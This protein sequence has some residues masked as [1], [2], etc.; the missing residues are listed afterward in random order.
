MAF[1]LIRSKG[2]VTGDGA[3]ITT[4]ALR[5]GIPAG[6]IMSMQIEAAVTGVLRKIDLATGEEVGTAEPVPQAERLKLLENLVKKR[7]PDAKVADV[8][9]DRAAN[10]DDLPVDP[11]D[12]KR[13][14]LSQLTRVIEAQ[15]EKVPEPLDNAPDRD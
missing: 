5:Q 3:L 14:P 13:M 6:L 2:P 10:L 9:E 7:L 8:E 11:E 12:V 1:A 15:F 4:K